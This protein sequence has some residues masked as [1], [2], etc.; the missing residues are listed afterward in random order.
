MILFMAEKILKLVS[1]CV[2]DT[3]IMS[4][5][6]NHPAKMHHVQKSIETH[7]HRTET[8]SDSDILSSASALDSRA[9]AGRDAIF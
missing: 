6:R 8:Y 9:L 4:H 7:F 3:K 1:M 2:R 5:F